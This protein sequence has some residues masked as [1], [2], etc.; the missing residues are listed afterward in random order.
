LRVTGCHSFFSS[1]PYFVFPV[2]PDVISLAQ[3]ATLF[4][5]KFTLLWVEGF[6]TCGA[7]GRS[8]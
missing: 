5:A 3:D 8:P 1:L 6:T 4:K 2:E 7:M